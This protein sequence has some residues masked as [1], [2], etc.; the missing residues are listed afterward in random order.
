MGRQVAVKDVVGDVD[1]SVGEP[2]GEGRIM[3]VEDSLGEGLPFH[4]LGL[5][6]P[7]LFSEFWGDCFSIGYV[8][9][10][11]SHQNQVHNGGCRSGLKL[12][13]VPPFPPFNSC[14]IVLYPISTLN[15]KDGI[16]I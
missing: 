12:P 2:P 13:A 10:V 4:F 1:L 5:F 11:L 9:R 15:N 6:F 14:F 7:E 8:V 16:T 3:I